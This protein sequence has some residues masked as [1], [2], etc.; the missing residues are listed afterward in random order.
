MINRYWGIDGEGK[1]RM[2][3]LYNMLIAT[4]ENGIYL[5]QENDDGL[6]TY[7]SLSFLVRLTAYTPVVFAYS[8]M[9][10]LTKILED[11]PNKDIY[12]LFRPELRAYEGGFE[13]VF[14]NDFE[15]NWIAG[16]FTVQKSKQRLVVWDVFKF[17]QSSFVKTLDRWEI[18][19]TDV[20]E[21]IKKMK[22]KREGFEHE[23]KDDV[24]AYCV[25]EGQQL[26]L[27]TRKLTEKHQEAGIP[28]KEYYGVGSTASV[29]LKKL[30]IEEKRDHGPEAIWGAI[31]RAFFG[32]RFENGWIGDIEGP[33]YNFDISSAYPYQLFRLPCLEH[34][35]WS[36]TR[37]IDVARRS[38]IALV[39]WHMGVNHH[40]YSWGPF[41]FRTKKGSIVF[42]VAGGNGFC[43]GE[44]FFAGQSIF[45]HVEFIMAYVYNTDCD[46]RPFQEIPLYYRERDRKSTRLNSSH[47]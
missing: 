21:H 31:M 34:G 10:D 11:L 27:L 38:T 19:D 5:S 12:H 47:H 20:R 37:N 29:I 24:R 39:W 17:F 2:P 18:G 32:G 3:H 14:W 9:Y 46:C 13:H 15:L 44:E 4:D 7:E 26:A 33:L 42:P 40:D 22:D 43:W 36:V 35:K 23:S 6:S 1:G 30:N 25:L 28:I 16:Q 8:F 41:P 45:P